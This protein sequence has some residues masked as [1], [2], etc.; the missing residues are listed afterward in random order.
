[1]KIYIY[2]IFLL[3]SAFGFSQSIKVDDKFELEVKRVDHRSRLFQVHFKSYYIRV[4]KD[5]KKIQFR[6]K[7]KTLTN[8]KE[9]FDP[10]KLFVLL[11]DKKVRL[12]AFDGDFAKLVDVQTDSY[13]YSYKP[14]I[15][16][17]FKDFQIEGYSDVESCI[18]FGTKKKPDVKPIYFNHIEIKSGS[19]NIYFAMPK[20]QS[21][22]ELYYGAIKLL[23]Y[24]MK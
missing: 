3:L 16:D 2:T 8:K 17:T 14:E 23:D 5:T 15:A 11:N 4:P 19:F 10:N 24:E 1:M 7:A 20:D 9:S 6:I 21:K 12:R 22:F 13:D 18:D